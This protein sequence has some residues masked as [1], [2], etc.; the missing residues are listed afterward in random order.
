MLNCLSIAI[1]KKRWTIT[2]LTLIERAILR[3]LIIIGRQENGYSCQD[4][5]FM[6]KCGIC[7]LDSEVLIGLDLGLRSN[8]HA[9]QLNK[10]ELSFNSL[11]LS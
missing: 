3:I 6:L 4:Y 1:L 11:D 10:L 7:T 5:G 9:N 8:M 2:L